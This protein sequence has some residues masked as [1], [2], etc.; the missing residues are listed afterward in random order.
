MRFALL[1]SVVALAVGSSKLDW[2]SD[3][4]IPARDPMSALQQGLELMHTRQFAEALGKF[5][6]GGKYMRIQ[7][8][9][10]TTLLQLCRFVRR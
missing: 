3:D 9:A 4:I 8:W 1:L 2:N 7:R 5:T 6:D 10:L